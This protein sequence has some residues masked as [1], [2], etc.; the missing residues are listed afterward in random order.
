MRTREPLTTTL[1]CIDYGD[2]ACSSQKQIKHSFIL[3]EAC[4]MNLLGRDLLLALGM[5]LIS[6]PDG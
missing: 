4:T 3:S 1:T 5:N 2:E 6:T